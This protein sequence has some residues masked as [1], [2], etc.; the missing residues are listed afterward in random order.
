MEFGRGY[1][2]RP[3]LTSEKFI[4][5]PF[6][7]GRIYKTG[8]LVRWLPDGSIDF[9]GRIDNQVKIRGFRVELNE[10]NNTILSYPNIKNSVTVVQNI[11]DTKSICSYIT[12]QTD[13]DLNNLK[14]F[15]QSILPNYMIPSYFCVIDSMP[16]TINGKIDKK[17][18]P[19]PT[20]QKTNRE[21][22]KPNSPTAEKIYSAIQSLNLTKSISIHDNFFNDIGFDSLSAMQLC[23]KLYEYNISIQD[24]SDYPTINLLA[25]KIDSHTDIS[26]FE[27]NLPYVRIKNESVK[28]DLTNTL[29]TGP[30]GFLGIHI[31][32]ELLESKDV[33]TIYCLV[34]KANGV[35]SENR[36]MKNIEYYF[37]NSLTSLI[38]KKVK[39]IDGDFTYDKLHL[40]DN[41]YENLLDSVTTVIHC[42]A[43]V[44][45]YGNY[46]S[47]N[48]SNVK[49]TQNIIDFCE[50]SRSN[51]CTHINYFYW[52]I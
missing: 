32:K 15:L 22:I 37:G 43:N 16:I 49:G 17:K 3:E 35:S 14:S 23:A 10:I 6:S 19:L 30:I 12:P 20:P 7:C 41:L 36:F 8:D 13:F 38:E 27:N 34:R 2:N 18:L 46:K 24:I 4:N 28:Y 29:L 47:F 1:L 39:I 26:L 51:T 33:S 31:L 48:D 44:K 52:W 50:K 11:N 45:H 42:G 5:N 9:I 40:D 25:H 21:I